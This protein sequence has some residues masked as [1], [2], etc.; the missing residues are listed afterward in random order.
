CCE[1]RGAS[2]RNCE[3]LAACYPLAVGR[4][5]RSRAAGLSPC[6]TQSE[7]GVG[8]NNV[9]ETEE[10]GGRHRPI[11]AALGR[12]TG[13]VE[14]GLE[15]LT[16]HAA[17]VVHKVAGVMHKDG[18]EVERTTE[19]DPGAATM[20]R[21]ALEPLAGSAPVAQRGCDPARSLHSAPGRSMDVDDAEGVV[22]HKTDKYKFAAVYWRPFSLPENGR[23]TL[24]GEALTFK[25][26]VGT[27]LTFD[28]AKA[29]AEKTSW[30]GGQGFV[31]RAESEDASAEETEEFYFSTVL[32]HRKKALDKIRAAME[33]AK[34]KLESPRGGV[35]EKTF[36]MSPDETLKKMKVIA[37]RK[38]RGVS[39]QD[40]FEVAWS[41]GQDCEKGAMYGPFLEKQ[42]KN[43]VVV[44]PWESGEFRGDWCGED[45]AQE[46][47]VT[48]NFMKVTIGQTLVE[49]KHTQRCRRV[50]NDR[51]IVQIKMEMKGFPYAD[52]FVVEVRHVASRVGNNDISIQL[53]MTVTFLK[54]CMFENKI[55]VSSQA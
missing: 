25:G 37:Q 50:G 49:V 43:N 8:K 42:A 24:R 36:R 51:C 1:L 33:K 55:R 5:A 7:M 54:S 6:F 21:A 14:K 32:M 41:E 20:S 29:A 26:I 47:T 3:E 35:K 48:F 10:K 16:D 31:I 45:Y 52:C 13:A 28:L 12:V 40:Y 22:F 11:P 4:S 9:T 44:G 15:T 39:L 17:P 18:V 53:G 27:R 38:L 34:T 30:L 19:D 2:A 23:M 46:R